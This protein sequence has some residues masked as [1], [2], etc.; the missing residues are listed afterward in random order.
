MASTPGPSF[1]LLGFGMEI[2]EVLGH[3]QHISTEDQVTLRFRWAAQPEA[4]LPEFQAWVL[5]MIAKRVV[6]HSANDPGMAE[7]HDL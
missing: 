3:C 2:I 6:H 4:H 7:M 1:L 5:I